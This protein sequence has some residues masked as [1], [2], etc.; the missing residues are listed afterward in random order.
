MAEQLQRLHFT[1]FSMSDSSD[2]D[3]PNSETFLLALALL[4]SL[5]V[6]GFVRFAHVLPMDYPLNDGGFFYTLIQDLQAADTFLPAYT[7]YN[8]IDIPFAYPPLAIF[9]TDIF[10]QLLN[11]SILDLIRLLPAALSCLTI[12]A[13]YLLARKLLPSTIQIVSATFAFALLPTAFDWLIV[14][15]GLT[16]AAGFFFAI[17][18]LVQIHSLY[19][20]SQK[21]HIFFAILF[22]SLT[23][24]SHPG[25][26]WFA[27][28]SGGILFAFLI[29]SQKVGGTSEVLWK[30]LRSRRLLA[31]FGNLAPQNIIKSIFVVLGTLFL[32]SPWWGTLIYRH[33]LQTILNPYQTETHS[34]TALITPFSLLFTNEP[35]VDILAVLGFLGLLVSLRERKFLL[36]SW[37][38]A[39]FIFEPRLSAVYASIP[40]ALLAG[41]GV[42]QAIL[43]LVT[44]QRSGGKLAKFTIGFLLIY[45]LI[46]AYLAPQYNSIS[47]AQAESMEWI[48]QHTPENSTFIVLTGNESYGNDYTSEW[49]PSLSRRHSIA[50]PQGHEW[51]PEKEFSRRISLHAELQTYAHTDITSL[52]AWAKNNQLTYAHIYIAKKALQEN[53]IPVNIFQESLEYSSGYELIFDN[54]GAL[55]YAIRPL[56]E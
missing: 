8:Q 7:S 12:P 2:K 39:V 51:L 21:R 4:S 56:S 41:I 28:Y 24:L 1:P 26:A 5:L 44:T 14:G 9:I 53:Q 30:R 16:R 25:T 36:P 34:L 20:T 37:L 32:T 55:V 47:H 23:I 38:L 40:M 6:G 52:E 17:L 54:E 22:A 10:S 29:S 42:D 33:G 43:P 11:I 45:A 3:N 19:T 49:F 46:S 15:A 48:S 27:F 13:F 18:T 31:D 50:T 35:L